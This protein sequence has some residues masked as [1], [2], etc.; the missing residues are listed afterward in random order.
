MLQELRKD[1]SA[2]ATVLARAREQ[3]LSKTTWLDE[4]IAE[5][6]NKSD[7]GK[8]TRHEG[9]GLYLISLLLLVQMPDSLMAVDC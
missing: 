5:K 9:D 8:S 1:F 2:E 4:L 7:T 3:A 6:S